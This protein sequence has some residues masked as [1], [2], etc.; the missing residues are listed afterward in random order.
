[1][2]LSVI[3]PTYNRSKSL[4]QLLSRLHEQENRDF[5]VIVVYRTSGDG[6]K[7]VLKQYKKLLTLKPIEQR[8]VGCLDALNQGIKNSNGEILVFVDDDALP[9]KTSFLDEHAKCYT[10][11]KVGGVVGSSMD[12]PEELVD[13]VPYNTEQT[14]LSNLQ[15]FLLHANYANRPLKGLE[16]YRVFISRAGM[17]CYNYNNTKYSLLGRGCNMSVRASAVANFCFPLDSWKRAY[18]FE[19]FMGLHIF[20]QGYS[21]LNK[22]SIGVYHVAHDSLGRG[23][24]NRTF[25]VELEEAFL[26]HRLKRLGYH[27]SSI[28]RLM[29]LLIDPLNSF[30]AF[31]LDHEFGRL[32]LEVKKFAL[33]ATNGRLISKK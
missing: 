4:S 3:I 19:Q 9:V 18:N 14:K 10:S 25:D 11:P 30:K 2:L 29:W 13:K 20:S 28:D 8:S 17:V 6:T 23:G 1:M 21:L 16:S 7:N 33:E 15:R 27:F 31:C 12:V 24:W 5:E 32:H 22:P 26:Y